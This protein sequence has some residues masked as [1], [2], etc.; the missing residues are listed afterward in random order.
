MKRFSL[1]FLLAGSF[2]VAAPAQDTTT[3][4]PVAQTDQDLQVIAFPASVIVRVD[5]DT[6]VP[7]QEAAVWFASKDGELTEVSLRFAVERATVLDLR[8]SSF[9]AEIDNV[10]LLTM[11][12]DLPVWVLAKG[13]AELLET[14]RTQLGE[15]GSL[16]GVATMAGGSG[17]PLL[18]DLDNYEYQGIVQ[19]TGPSFEGG[20]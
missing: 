17:Y 12:P 10:T 20:E 1:L 13:N 19:D 4:E 18:F 6:A 16:D 8:S 15:G 7:A 9:Q 14:V 3:T 5:D 2:A 11:T